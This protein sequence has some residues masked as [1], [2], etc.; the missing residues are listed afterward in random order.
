MA[1][2]HEQTGL[3]WNFWKPTIFPGVS[4]EPRATHRKWYTKEVQQYQHTIAAVGGFDNCRIVAR[5]SFEEIDEWLAEG[6][7]WH[8]E[9][10]DAKGQIAWVGFIDQFKVNFG[11]LTV[12]YG[13][14]KHLNN[15][16]QVVFQLM[17]TNVN[18]PEGMERKITDPAEDTDS[19]KIY[20][21]RPVTIDAGGQ[22]LAVAE[23]IRDQWLQRR[24]WPWPTQQ[25]S[26]GSAGTEPQVIISGLGY[27]HKM[28]FPFEQESVGTQTIHDKLD[29]VVTAH[30]DLLFNTGLDQIA[31]N[32][33]QVPANE[34]RQR[35]AWSIV[36]ELTGVG[37][38]AGNR[39]VAG[40]YEGQAFI[41]RAIGEEADYIQALNEKQ[42]QVRTPSGGIVE[43]WLVRPG[44]WLYF[45]SFLG[46]VDRLDPYEDPRMM[47][48]EQ[49][50]FT[51]PNSLVLI[52][53]KI[54]DQPDAMGTWGLRGSA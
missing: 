28:D 33:V 11:S 15:K 7:N 44:R 43:P 54:T 30:P 48:I 49:A 3:A 35:K 25:L 17:D 40:I 29:A 24:A 42:Q 1:T 10:S 23:E 26:L 50:R 22:L 31:V 21:T 37:D 13:P 38:G 5:L 27:Y 12:T 9:V 32:A 4:Y 19:Q 6:L 53:A 2:L 8:I 52:G 41:Y 46:R 36:R 14:M 34:N 20:G 47:L 45:P 39:Y 18:P 16:V 51:A